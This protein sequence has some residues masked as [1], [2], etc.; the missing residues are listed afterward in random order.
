MCTFR[1][2][3]INIYDLLNIHINVNHPIQHAQKKLNWDFIHLDRYL[4]EGAT[5]IFTGSLYDD[6][7]LIRKG[8]LSTVFLAFKSV[9]ISFL[10]LWLFLSPLKEHFFSDYILNMNKNKKFLFGRFE[11]Y[12]YMKV[13]KVILE[14]H[15][16]NKTERQDN[17]H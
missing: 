3:L 13:N 14:L 8:R 15:F 16:N 4:I 1:Y 5:G 7:S 9:Y 12:I 11:L 10:M 6:S 2:L 17:Y